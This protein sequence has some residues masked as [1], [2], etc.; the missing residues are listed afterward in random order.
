MGVSRVAVVPGRVT[1]LLAPLPPYRV[2]P[3][4]GSDLARAAFSANLSPY[5]VRPLRGWAQLGL[6]EHYKFRNV[7]GRSSLPVAVARNSGT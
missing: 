4:C 5:R 1:E 6:L 7:A 2:R 3:L